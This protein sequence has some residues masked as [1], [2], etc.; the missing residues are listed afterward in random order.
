MNPL[1]LF[2]A[3][4][5]F[6]AYFLLLAGLTAAAQ[7]CLVKGQVVDYKSKQLM[8]SRI[9]FEKQPDASLTVISES[10][11]RGFKATL[12]E[13]GVYSMMVSAP[14]HISER[15]EFDLLADSMKDKR[16]AFFNFELVPISLNEVLPFHQLLFDVESS[17]ISPGALGELYRLADILKENPTI[18]IQLEGYTDSQN[19][20]SK[21]LALSR[22]R[23]EA[24]LEWLVAHG[25]EK[26][27]IKVKAKGSEKALVSGSGDEIRKVNRRVEIRVIEI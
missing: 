8:H 15:V 22:K 7:N 1:N 27:R 17:A 6:L 10:G 12:F 14:G 9:T 23:N 11:P 25:I 26:K 3:K 4:F 24:I 19:N 2:S 16:E 18:K 13:R 21:S 20:S 5:N